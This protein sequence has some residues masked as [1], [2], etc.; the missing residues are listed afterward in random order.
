M[1]KLVL[2]TTAILVI[3]TFCLLLC[4]GRSKY[5]EACFMASYSE[6]S[7]VAITETLNKYGFYLDVFETPTITDYIL[8]NFR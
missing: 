5:N 8:S 1:K 3:M 2:K 6:G 7:D 4:N